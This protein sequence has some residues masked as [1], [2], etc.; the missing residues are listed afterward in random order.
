MLFI[1]GFLFLFLALTAI[2]LSGVECNHF[3]NFSKGVYNI[4]VK[5]ITNQTF[6]LGKGNFGL[7]VS[8]CPSEQ[9]FRVR[10]FNFVTTL[11]FIPIRYIKN[12]FGLGSV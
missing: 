1:K 11:C 12:L 4:S 6:D 8:V 3:S 2:L 10:G 7:Q 9:K 5:L